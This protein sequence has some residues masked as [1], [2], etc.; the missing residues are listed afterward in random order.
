M[1]DDSIIDF[2]V[3]LRVAEM[4]NAAGISAVSR[5][6]RVSDTSI[7]RK[8]DGVLRIKGRHGREHIFLLSEAFSSDL[9]VVGEFYLNWMC[10]CPSC[11]V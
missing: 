11:S 6:V 10:E 2:V 4:L 9:P 5:P 8:E 7:G 3:M 1:Q